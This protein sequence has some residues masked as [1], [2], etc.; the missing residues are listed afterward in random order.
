MSDVSIPPQLLTL[1]AVCE[2]LDI[3]IR[4]GWR[5]LS[6]GRLYEADVNLGGIRGRRWRADRLTEWIA[7]GC[8]AGWRCRI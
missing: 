3:S 8:P 2:V 5:M 6:S 4:Q 7:A 1:T